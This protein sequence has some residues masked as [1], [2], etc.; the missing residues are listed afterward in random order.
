MLLLFALKYLA[1]EEIKFG[2]KSNKPDSPNSSQVATYI[3]IL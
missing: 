1:G 2:N 3:S